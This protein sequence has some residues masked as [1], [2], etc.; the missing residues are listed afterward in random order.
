V[1]EQDARVS[2]GQVLVAMTGLPGTGKSALA[3]AVARAIS[4]PVFSVDPLEAT[5]NRAGITREHRSGHAA[6]DLAATLA[7]A[8]L[9]LGQSAVVD[10][11]NGLAFVRQWWR[12]IGARYGVRVVTLATVCADV[13]VHRQRVEGRQRD[14]DGFLY[15][16]TW[17]DIESARTE[18]EPPTEA[19]LVLDT[20]EP[21]ADNTALVLRYLAAAPP[22]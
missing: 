17:S 6:Y 7:E 13:A 22:A 5:L 2:A 4:A 15:E 9:R 8:Q 3:E 14:L 18:Y 1:I 21:L 10:A 20:V 12:D 16:L 19:D 11:V